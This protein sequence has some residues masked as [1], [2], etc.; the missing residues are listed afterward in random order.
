MMG[1][2]RLYLRYIHSN[3]HIGLYSKHIYLSQPSTMTTPIPSVTKTWHSAPHPAISPTRQ[4][5]SAKGK[6]IVITGGGTGI[7]ASIAHAFA[8]AGSTEIAI[9]S[10]RQTK[11]S[12]TAQAIQTAIPDTKILTLSTDVTDVASVN[13]AFEEILKTFG[14]IDV[15]VNNAGAISAFAPAA[16]SDLADWWAAYETN[17]KGSLVVAQAFLRTA[18]KG[19]ILLNITTGLVHMPVMIPGMSAYV[20]SKLATAKVFNYIASENPDIHVFNLQPGAIKTDLN[21]QAPAFDHRKFLQH[22]PSSTVADERYCSRSPRA[23][24]RMVS[25]QGSGVLKGEVCLGKLGC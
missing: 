11:L 15:L 12:E 24:C 7:G 16:T 14:R 1:A 13:N 22:C 4:E 9:L 5:N 20:S 18:R 25:K 3:F 21:N 10:R 23:L 17:V 19:S 6:S 8:V 2:P